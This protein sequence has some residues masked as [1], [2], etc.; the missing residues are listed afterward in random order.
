MSVMKATLGTMVVVAVLIMAYFFFSPVYY[1]LLDEL[2]T[3]TDDAALGAEGQ[4]LINF[5]YGLFFYGLSTIVL[6]GILAT[7]YW[8]YMYVRRVYY[9]TEVI[10]R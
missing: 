10:R 2:N 5:S 4:T 9:A 8:L 3:V 6:L 7:I 1:T